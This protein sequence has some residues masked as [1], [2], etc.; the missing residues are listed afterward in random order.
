M[1]DEAFLPL[2]EIIRR[3]LAFPAEIV[4]T[5]AGVRSRIHAC[6]IEMPVELSVLRDADGALGIG[7][8]PP[9][10]YVD[11]SFRPS[12]HRVSFSATLSEAQDGE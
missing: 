8:T 3:T 10:Y 4:D 1:M 7:S 12:Y 9:L 11:T 6:Q 5:E 2:A